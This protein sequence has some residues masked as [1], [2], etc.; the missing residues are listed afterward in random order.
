MYLPESIIKS[1]CDHNYPLIYAKN[2]YKFSVSTTD[3]VRSVKEGSAA[4]PD[5]DNFQGNFFTS[6]YFFLTTCSIV[7]GFEEI[8]EVLERSFRI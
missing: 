3:L 1:L 8:N 6:L 4:G 2:I 7:F 5:T